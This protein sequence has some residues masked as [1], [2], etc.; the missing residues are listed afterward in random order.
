M[1]KFYKF[2]FIALSINALVYAE[3]PIVDV[4]E[5]YSDNTKVLM[6]NIEEVN[7]AKPLFE[8]D[9]DEG[10][11]INIESISSEDSYL[12]S[13]PEAINKYEKEHLLNNKDSLLDLKDKEK[14]RRI[15]DNQKTK[16]SP[17]GYRDA[18]F[19]KL[20]LA[21][22]QLE[23]QTKYEFKRTYVSP[24]G[25]VFLFDFYLDKDFKEKNKNLYHEYFEKLSIKSFPSEQ[26]Y[27][28]TVKVTKP[29]VNYKA[30]FKG[31]SLILEYIAP[32][33]LET[34]DSYKYID[35]VE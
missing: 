3:N 21:G 13:S 9:V 2:V 10:R 23:L 27:R 8:E 5:D 30:Y 32:K 24:K 12:L 18:P 33:K 6:D 1:N 25:K 29:T 11:Y 20:L 16:D 28:I 22:K 35:S 4:P 17:Y 19:V 14:S 34:L 26:F 31:K 15:L 7:D